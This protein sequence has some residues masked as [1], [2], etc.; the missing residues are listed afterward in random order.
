MFSSFEIRHSYQFP[1]CLTIARSQ[2]CMSLTLRL[3]ILKTYISP[4]L[5]VTTNFEGERKLIYVIIYILIFIIGKD[6]IF[7]LG[8]NQTFELQLLNYPAYIYF[9]SLNPTTKHLRF[10]QQVT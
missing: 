1:I 4:I 5:I 6:L 10:T 8:S 7:F 2:G 9:V 3:W